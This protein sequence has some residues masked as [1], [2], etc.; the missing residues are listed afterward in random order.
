MWGILF[1]IALFQINIQQRESIHA[2]NE[3]LM[4]KV[5]CGI[6]QILLFTHLFAYHIFCVGR[7]FILF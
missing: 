5:K 4:K 6:I 3:I 2:K 7:R 1:L